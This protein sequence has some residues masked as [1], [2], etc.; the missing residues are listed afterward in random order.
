MATMKAVRFH[1]FGGP[2]VLRYESVP[3]PEPATGEV[4]IRIHATSVN[5]VDCSIRSG[6]ARMFLK[7]PLPA[8]LG[9]DFSGVVEEVGSGVASWTPG[10]EVY[11]H[12]SIS[13]SGTYAEYIAVPAAICA[14]KPASIDHTH[15][16][17][18]PLAGLTAWQALFE[19]AALTSGQKVLIQAGAGGVGTFA[20]QFA[21]LK[22]AHV[23]ATASARNQ[24]F[25][26]SLG[27][28]QPIDYAI[29]RF[30]DAVQDADAVI[31]TMGGE[32]RERSFRCL[33]KGG[34]MVALTGPP[35]SEEL[36]KVHG[37]RTTLML[38]HGDAAQLSEIA[39]LVDAGK[40][41][42]VVD[43]VLPLCDMAE[44]HRIS[45]TRHARGKVCITCI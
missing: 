23:A 43:R 1:E 25:L 19:A 7:Q 45:E 3:R 2:D 31:E 38:V 42:P 44:A 11:G 6:A 9:W 10:D 37:V 41:H 30:E 26:R 18:I 15:A 20:I 5:P 22:G 14:R 40:V 33:K 35:P 16:A 32:I 39:Q 36:A 21:E 28:G 29:T 8:I 13:G 17:A 27:A 4:L 24:D 12:P 34:I